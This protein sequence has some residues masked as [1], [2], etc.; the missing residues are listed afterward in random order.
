MPRT[1]DPSSLPPEQALAR[2]IEGNRRFREE[3]GSSSAR[4][5]SRQLAVEGQRPF[6]IIL[7]CS[8]SRTPVEILFDEGFGDLFVVRIAGNIV[9]PSVVGSIEFAASQF[10]SRLVVVMGHTRCG[11][12]AA[13]VHAIETG[14]G[15]DSKNIRAI[16]DRIAPHIEA[17]VRPGDPATILREAT[18]ANVRASADHLRHGS[19]II[20]ELVGSGRVA[21]VGAEYEL[22]TGAV[23]FFD[24]VPLAAGS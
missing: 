9:A 15:P 6:A 24:G 4:T 8:D 12:I 22:E 16:T 13:T 14:L 23:H 11:A 21:V 3:S 18:R 19:P 2:L 10:G 17:L 5:W 20:E 7:G 1:R